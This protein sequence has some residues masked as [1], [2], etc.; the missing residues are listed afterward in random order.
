MTQNGRI[1]GARATGFEP[2]LRRNR[3]PRAESWQSP[4]VTKS[5]GSGT[6]TRQYPGSRQGTAGTGGRPRPVSRGRIPRRVMDDRGLDQQSPPDVGNS[7]RMGLNTLVFNQTYQAG[8]D[9][10]TQLQTSAL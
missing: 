4:L 3:Y 1:R 2:R 8:T 10:E 9:L 5:H 6:V 7:I